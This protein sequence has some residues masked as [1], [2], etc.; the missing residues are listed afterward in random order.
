MNSR[1]IKAAA[2]AA[3][4]FGALTGAS[5]ARAQIITGAGASF[6]A[7][8]YQRWAQ[9]YKQ[10]TGQQINY[11]SIG[12]SGGVKNI[13]ARAVDF[14]ASDGPMTASEMQNAP[15]VLHIPMV[16]GAVVLAYNVRGVPEHIKLTGPVIADIYLGAITRWNDP[17]ITALNPGVNFPAAN[18]VPAF[19]SDGSGT[20]NIFTNYLS[21]V[22]P[23][24]R[25]RVGVGKAVK[26]PKGIGGKGNESVAALVRQTPGAIGYVELAY[27]ENN[28]LSYADV[29]NRKGNFIR[30]TIAATT[31]AAE[32]ARLPSDFRLIITNTP[33]A[34]GYPI[35]GYTWILVRRDT[36][37]GVKK[38]LQ[39]A[40]DEGQKMAAPSGYAPLPANVQ[41]RA[42]AVVNSLQ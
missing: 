11:Q 19:R 35:V 25:E 16:A 23:A 39:W 14:G 9:A 4:G 17:R 27:A 31:T 22:S 20:T 30:P 26:F 34:Q 29:Q 38:F 13:T 36:K 33:A 12:S 5:A 24:F 40:L 2:V 10:A 32:A 7:P 6:P 28:K 42:L 37:P 1:T 21:Q 41:K 18:I 8:L 3:I 15:G